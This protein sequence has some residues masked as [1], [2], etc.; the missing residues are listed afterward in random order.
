MRPEASLNLLRM[1]AFLLAI[2]VL[3]SCT[4]RPEVIPP[5]ETDKT[6]EK[7]QSVYVTSHGWHTGIVINAS[8][9]TDELVALKER[10]PG[11]KYIEFGWGDTGFYQAPEIT[12]MLTIKAV[13]WPTQSI[14]HV[15]GFN[16]RPDQYFP[17]SEVIE[18]KLT[19]SQVENLVK[20]LV[21]SFA[22]ENDE[23]VP[24]EKGLYGNSQFYQGVGSYYAFNTC[25]KWT[26]KALYSAG[27]D[28][29]PILKLTADSVMDSFDR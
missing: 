21:S 29:N 8:M 10:F 26:A 14:M 25:N 3:C 15:V 12:A 19:Q 20:F 9:I 16:T 23:V 17:G 27:V 28:I 22:V 7:N 18:V 24:L 1:L 2:L 4:T 6:E 5:I 13:F 11:N